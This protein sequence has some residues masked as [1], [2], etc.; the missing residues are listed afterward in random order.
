MLPVTLLRQFKPV[1]SKLFVLLLGLKIMRLLCGLPTLHGP[2]AVTVGAGED[3]LRCFLIGS[4]QR[5]RHPA[6][7]LRDLNQISVRC[8][9]LSSS[10]ALSPTTAPRNSIRRAGRRRSRISASCRNRKGRSAGRGRGHGVLG[11]RIRGPLAFLQASRPPSMCR[12]AVR[13]ASCAACTAM[14]ERSPKAQ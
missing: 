5:S 7:G 4:P 9:N 3:M 1:A 13:P 14:A 10:R 11:Q 6:Q 12:D 8:R 2:C